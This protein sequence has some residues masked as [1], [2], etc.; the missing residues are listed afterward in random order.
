MRTLKVC[1]SLL[2][3]MPWL[4]RF[5]NFDA[6]AVVGTSSSSMT[7]RL[8][9]PARPKFDFDE[10]GCALGAMV[11]SLRGRESRKAAVLA[12]LKM[13]RFNFGGGFLNTKKVLSRRWRF[14]GKL[15]TFLRKALYLSKCGGCVSGGRLSS[16]RS[17]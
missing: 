3:T 11:T 12:I 7:T 17:F 4:V 2:E 8:L 1:A 10:D 15:Y 16:Q 9:P 6:R 14:L 13:S 5:K